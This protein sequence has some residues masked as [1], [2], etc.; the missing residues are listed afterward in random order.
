MATTFVQ[1]SR[2]RHWEPLV[3]HVDRI[4]VEV[5]WRL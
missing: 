4:Q 3:F 2:V 1:R 5:V